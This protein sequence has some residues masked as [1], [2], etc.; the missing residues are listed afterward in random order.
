MKI[1]FLDFT[2]FQME[3][4]AREK[5]KAQYLFGES[6]KEITLTAWVIRS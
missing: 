1:N 4:F 2:W 5:K 3:I 6:K